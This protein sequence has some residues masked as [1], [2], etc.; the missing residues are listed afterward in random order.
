MAFNEPG[1]KS[2]RSWR[3]SWPSGAAGQVGDETEELAKSAF[4]NS[5]TQLLDQA[6]RSVGSRLQNCLAGDGEVVRSS[7]P[8]QDPRATVLRQRR[9]G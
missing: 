2:A 4:C 3:H 9:Q 5:C 6:V 1:W 7:P 8:E